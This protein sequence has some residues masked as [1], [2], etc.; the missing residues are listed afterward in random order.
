MP[1]ILSAQGEVLELRRHAR[2]LAMPLGRR[3]TPG[4][5]GCRCRAAVTLQWVRHGAFARTPRSNSSEPTAAH[6]RAGEPP[7]DELELLGGGRALGVGE[8]ATHPPNTTHG[9]AQGWVGRD[10]EASA[11][12]RSLVRRNYLLAP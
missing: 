9:P 11:D 6:D 3:H 8:V 1:R 7:H 10:E 5:R 4:V 2:G 12:E